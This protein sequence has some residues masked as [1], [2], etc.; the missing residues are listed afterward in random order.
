MK[1]TE[2]YT[3]A[4]LIQQT[5]QKIFSLEKDEKEKENVSLSS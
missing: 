1:Y 2:T 3:E 5:S 4:A